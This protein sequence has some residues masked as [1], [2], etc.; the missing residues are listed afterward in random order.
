MRQYSAPPPGAPPN[1]IDAGAAATARAVLLA[2]GASPQR[3]GEADVDA[4]L[5]CAPGRPAHGR[6]RRSQLRDNKPRDGA[7][8]GPPGGLPSGASWRAPGGRCWGSWSA[9]G[10]LLGGSCG[11]LGPPWA[12]LGR[13]GGLLGSSWDPPGGASRGASRGASWG[14]S[15]GLLGLLNLPGGPPG[16]APRDSWGLLRTSSGAPGRSEDMSATASQDIS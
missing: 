6:L 3:V 16:G 11:L 13:S 10:G 9:S 1:P 14:A 7:L 2:E 8:L 15:W 4:R 5:R 12:L